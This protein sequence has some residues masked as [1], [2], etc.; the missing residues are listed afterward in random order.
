VPEV[1]NEKKGRQ[2]SDQDGFGGGLKE[3]VPLRCLLACWLAASPLNFLLLL[4]LHL[5]LS[6]GGRTSNS[7]ARHFSL[8]ITTS[9]EMQVSQSLPVQLDPSC[10]LGLYSTAYTFS[11]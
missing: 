6:G 3:C 5:E 4:F 9:T 8:Q 7:N 11:P 1:E 10:G 2:F